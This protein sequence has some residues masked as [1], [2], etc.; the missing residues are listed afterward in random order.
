[1]LVPD[2]LVPVVLV[3]AALVPAVPVADLLVRTIA[4]LASEACF[5]RTKDLRTGPFQSVIRL[6]ANRVLGFGAFSIVG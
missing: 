5:E 2:L 1:L 4:A 6:P 3:L